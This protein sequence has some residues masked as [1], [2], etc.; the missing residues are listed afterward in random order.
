MSMIPSGQVGIYTCSTTETCCLCDQPIELGATV[1]QIGSR[2]ATM[3]C[4]DK[5]LT[6]ITEK[7]AAKRVA[8]QEVLNAN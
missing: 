7:R 3:D 1:K 8:E 5:A 2:F 4:V 6:W